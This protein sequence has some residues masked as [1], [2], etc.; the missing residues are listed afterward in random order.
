MS[1]RVS[2]NKSRSCAVSCCGIIWPYPQLYEAWTENESLLLLKLVIVWI[3]VASLIG[4]SG[5]IIKILSCK[6]IFEEPLDHKIFELCE[7]SFYHI[8]RGFDPFQA[9]FGLTATIAFWFCFNI[10]ML[11]KKLLCGWFQPPV[12]EPQVIYLKPLPPG[13]VET[14]MWPCLLESSRKFD[15][16]NPSIENPI[17]STVPEIQVVEER[18]RMGQKKK[19]SLP[20]SVT[21][22]PDT[23]PTNQGDFVPS[24]T[25]LPASLFTHDKE[26]KSDHMVLK[27]A[28]TN[29]MAYDGDGLTNFD[30]LE[31][32]NVESFYNG[33]IPIK[34]NKTD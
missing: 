16:F 4:F 31:Q 22:A 19:K 26:L 17:N 21:F 32:A 30:E 24:F 6:Y 11:L 1:Y 25:T 12:E 20:K 18:P 29:D 14:L 13:V 34:T 10:I 2:S 15:S 7:I 3:I 8:G 28:E 27:P 9:V 5:I 23:F 33:I